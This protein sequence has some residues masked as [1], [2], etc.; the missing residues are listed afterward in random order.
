[1]PA[2]RGVGG[3]VSASA[4]SVERGAWSGVARRGGTSRE[5][6][7]ARPV[8]RICGMRHGRGLVY[9]TAYCTYS[10]IEYLF[11]PIAA[12]SG[13]SP[14]AAGQCTCTRR[15]APSAHGSHIFRSH[16]QEA[17]PGAAG[18]RTFAAGNRSGRNNHSFTAPPRTQRGISEVC[19][20]AVHRAME[21]G[22]R[23][24][25]APPILARTADGVVCIELRL[26]KL[27]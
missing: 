23:T 5:F 8:F 10:F 22:R 18:P 12:A 6:R 4:R 20:H 7:R 3:A 21:H 2:E 25:G 15:H 11:S 13:Q 27:R 14:T 19:A 24:R 1:M 9:H 16:T 17:G 26:G